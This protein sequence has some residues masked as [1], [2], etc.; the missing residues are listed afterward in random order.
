MPPEPCPQYTCHLQILDFRA[1]SGVNIFDFR[2][3]WHYKIADF[4]AKSGVNIFDFRAKD[5]ISRTV[6]R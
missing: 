3:A 1:K 4:R 2:A 5:D 6:W